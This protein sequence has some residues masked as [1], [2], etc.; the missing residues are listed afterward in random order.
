MQRGGNNDELDL[1][2]QVQLRIATQFI[3]ESGERVAT[4]FACWST[5]K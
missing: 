1:V 5:F 3:Y 2:M 4:T